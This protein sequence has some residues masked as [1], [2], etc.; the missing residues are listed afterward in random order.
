[1]HAV[2]DMIAA[3]SLVQLDSFMSVYDLLTCRVRAVV[4]CL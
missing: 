2:G 3:L 4:T 1:M